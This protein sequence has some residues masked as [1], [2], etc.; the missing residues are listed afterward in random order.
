MVAAQQFPEDNIQLVPPVGLAMKMVKIMGAVGNIAKDGQN[1]FQNYAFIQSDDVLNAVRA[2][3]VKHNVIVFPRML[4]YE[5][6]AETKGFHAVVQFEFTLIDAETGEA[7]SGQ[8]F[9]E[10]SDSGDKSFSKAGTSALKY[11]LLKTFMIAAGEPDADKES[12]E[13]DHEQARTSKAALRGN[14]QS[15]RRIPPKSNE[16]ASNSSAVDKSQPHD[17]DAWDKSTIEVFVNDFKGKLATDQLL[18]ALNVKRFLEWTGG[19]H[20]AYE[21]AD[22]FLNL[23]KETF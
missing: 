21:A 20:A 7:M 23:A 3:M 4:G 18:T 14:G 16:K 5:Q 17:T 12:P 11:W 19:R 10:A 1:K 13:H 2:E 6:S 9:G 8:W 15:E 22:V